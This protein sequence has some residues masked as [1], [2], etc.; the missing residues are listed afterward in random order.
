MD[1]LSK[2]DL[3]QLI[4]FYKDKCSDL[5]MQYLV[6]QINHKYQLAKKIEEEKNKVLNDSNIALSKL[7]EQ[8]YKLQKKYDTDIKKVNQTKKK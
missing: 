5:E 6:L 2:D 7:N 3:T 4:K 8:L 1:N